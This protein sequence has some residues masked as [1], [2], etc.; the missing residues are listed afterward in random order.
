[1]VRCQPHSTESGKTRCHT[2]KC[3]FR[4]IKR[5]RDS[6]NIII[7]LKTTQTNVLHV[8]ILASFRC[9]HVRTHKHTYT[10]STR[11]CT[12]LVD[13]SVSPNYN[14]I[15]YIELLPCSKGSS[16]LNVNGTNL[17]GSLADRGF[18]SGYSAGTFK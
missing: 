1:M 4:L 2:L 17:L 6:C 12:Y 3:L 5:F 7:S 18:S 9:T 14:V 13:V 11:T 10:H 8:M 15:M 16:L